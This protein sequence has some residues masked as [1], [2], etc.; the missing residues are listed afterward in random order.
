MTSS[1]VALGLTESEPRL[2]W[3]SLAL[4]GSVIAEFVHQLARRDGRPRLVESVSGSV[5]GVAVLA[6]L[7]PVIALVS[8]PAGAAG[9]V[10]WAAAG[11]AALLTQALALP[12]RV[13]GAV[14]AVLGTLVGGVLGGL[15]ADGTL[16]ASLVLGALSSG[17][18]L[19]L[20][21]LLAL[22]P[23]SGRAPGWLALAVAPLASTGTVGYVVLRLMLG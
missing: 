1:A 13:V 6:S 23:A 19:V 4:A 18:V 21:R 16:A 11:A 3:L 22:L 7:S 8:S 17:V 14:G 9:V 15:F 5:V 12:S 2:E 20:H 10:V